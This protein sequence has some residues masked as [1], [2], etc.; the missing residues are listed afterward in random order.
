MGE[1]YME[2]S[3]LGISSNLFAALIYFIGAIANGVILIFIA[4]GYILIFEENEK[5]KRTAVK[6]FILTVFFS[7]LTSLINW[8]SA[9][10]GNFFAMLTN[11]S[12]NLNY[13]TIENI[14]DSAK[15]DIANLFQT[16]GYAISNISFLA[17][18]CIALIMIILGFRAYKQI[19]FKINWIDKI[20]DKHFF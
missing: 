15:F 8:L 1:Y 3:K 20:L 5:L 7:V 19:D 4:A 10:L 17:Y 9:A 11:M 14:N 18:L 16:I 13:I 12:R 6:A 2:K